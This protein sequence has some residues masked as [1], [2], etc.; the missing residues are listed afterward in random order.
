M[1]RIFLCTAFLAA[2]PRAGFAVGEA[3]PPAAPGVA[4]KEAQV[5]EPPRPYRSR[6]EIEED[7]RALEVRRADL[8]AC[9]APAHPD[10]RA[11]ERRLAILRAQLRLLDESAR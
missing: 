4:A 2:L 11:V 10:V 8:L 9:Y 7:I 5:P 6:R 1:Y 3:I